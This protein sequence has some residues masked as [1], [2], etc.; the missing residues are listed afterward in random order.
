MLIILIR[1]GNISNFINFDSNSTI[2]CNTLGF[3][4]WKSI[5]NLK[6]LVS[7]SNN[8]SSL[9]LTSS[10]NLFISFI[11]SF[12]NVLNSLSFLMESYS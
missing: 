10:F 4:Y 2:L 7:P 1:L 5:N 9:F 6:S 3:S 11:L 8:L 12:A